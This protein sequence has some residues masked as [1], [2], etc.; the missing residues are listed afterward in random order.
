MHERD[1]RH[2]LLLRLLRLLRLLGV[3]AAVAAGVLLSAAASN[4]GKNRGGLGANTAEDALWGWPLRVYSLEL[5][6]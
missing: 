2:P 1:G 6:I 4:G 5:G 3:A